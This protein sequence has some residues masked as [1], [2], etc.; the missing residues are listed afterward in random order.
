MGHGRRAGKGCEMQET[1][2]KN[3]VLTGMDHT[4]LSKC[5]KELQFY[6]LPHVVQKL[7]TI[8]NKVLLNLNR[9]IPLT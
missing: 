1:P 3:V 8:K 6:L 5:L 7:L 2:G 9:S 4:H